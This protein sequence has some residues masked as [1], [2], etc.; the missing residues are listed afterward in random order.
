MPEETCFHQAWSS[1]VEGTSQV[2]LGSSD[3]FPWPTGLRHRS[4][5]TE[6]HVHRPFSCTSRPAENFLVYSEVTFCT[7]ICHHLKGRV[8]LFLKWEVPGR[9]LPYP[10][11]VLPFSADFGHR[12]KNHFFLQHLSMV[13]QH[14]DSAR[15]RRALLELNQW[16]SIALHGPSFQ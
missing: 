6:G 13:L 9:D 12:K 7:V 5:V 14:R 15:R 4:Q 16:S 1:S 3:L 11:Q 8:T 2:V 10:E